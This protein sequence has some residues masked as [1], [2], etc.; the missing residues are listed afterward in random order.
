M[1]IQVLSF[2]FVYI[3][4]SLEKVIQTPLFAL[5]VRTIVFIHMCFEHF[6]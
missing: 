6:D 1:I 4:K 5:F 3:N 2:T